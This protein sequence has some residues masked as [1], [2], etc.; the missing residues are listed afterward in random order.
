MEQKDR[1]A[2]QRLD[3]LVEKG[4]Q[5]GALTIGDLLTLE[6]LDLSLEE[7]ERF[8]DRIERL[9]ID[10]AFEEPPRAGVGRSRGHDRPG[11]SAPRPFHV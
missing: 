8:Y 7:T 9:N 4:R 6:E 1:T 5:T 10:V 2:A 11:V 3:A